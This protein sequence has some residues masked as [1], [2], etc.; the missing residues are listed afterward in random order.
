M[1]ELSRIKDRYYILAT[2]SITDPYRLVLKQGDT[3]AVFN[4]F[5]DISPIGKGDAGIYHEGTR[6]VSWYE[7]RIH[8]K[9]PLLLSSEVS[10]DNTHLSID[11]TN[12]DILSRGNRF[13]KR[14]TIH[15]MRSIV[16]MDGYCFEQLRIKNFGQE[17]LE[18]KIEIIT[19]ADFKD[20]FEIRGLRR[21]RKGRIMPLLYE[22]RCMK[23]SYEG[24]DKVVRTTTLSFSDTPYKTEGKTFY[25][26]IT[27]PPHKTRYL[28]ST[29]SCNRKN[30]RDDP[31]DFKWAMRNSVKKHVRLTSNFADIYTSNELFNE[32]IKRAISDLQIML[33]ETKYGLYPYGGIPWYCTAFG[34][35]G[36]ITALESLW[37]NPE[38]AKGVLMYLAANQAQDSDARRVSEPG[39]ILHE[40]RKGEMAAMNEIPFGLYY[41]SIDSTPLFIMLAGAY[42]KRTGDIHLIKRIW[43]NIELALLWMDKYGDIDQDGFLEYIPH[44]NGLVNQGW[45]DSYDAVFHKDGT[46]PEGHIALCEVQGYM[47][48]AK[49]E[50]A[51]LAA[52]VGKKQLAERLLKESETLRRKFNKEFWDEKLGSYVLALDGKK[53][54]CRVMT[55]NAGHAL[56]TGIAYADKAKKTADRLLSDAMFSGWGIRTVSSDEVLYNPISYHNGSVWPH[57]NA[58]IARGLSSYGF[59]EHFMRVFTAIFDAAIFMEFR[60]LPELFSGFHRRKGVGPTLYPFACSPQAWAA[61][62]LLMMLQACLGIEFEPENNSVILK[63][64]FLPPFL[65]QVRLNNLTAT[66][67]NKVDLTLRRYGEDVT[68]EVIKK[69]RDLNI[70]VIK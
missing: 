30:C 38:I 20:V 39:K 60:R 56:F 46:F 12:P 48:S 43:K 44:K 19:D 34:R 16:L 28:Y 25:F 62:S 24:L 65:E 58:L 54:P 29:V 10:E 14:N 41:G 13:L 22:E 4:R 70:I 49:R 42:W 45:K 32:S 40:T 31:S 59:K 15:I 5:G 36:I 37:I 2:S 52:I 55:S 17:S 67:K 51:R 9:R 3:F 8:G 21:H 1:S 33:T 26:S 23:I 68:I 7:L 6:M 47:Y 27:L 69:S 18:F 63:N 61:G 57:D 66:Y 35:D 11:L 64:P 50:A 53:K